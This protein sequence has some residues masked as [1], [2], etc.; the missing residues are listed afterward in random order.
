VDLALAG[1][2]AL[3]TGASRGIG[4][5]VA[6]A[7]AAEGVALHLA[8]RSRERLEEAAG[9]LRRAHGVPVAVHPGDLAV[10]G[11]VDALADAVAAATGA[12]D[13]LVNNAGAIPAGDLDAVDGGTWRSAW[14]LK[15]LGYV[16]LSRRCLALMRAAGSGVIVN[17]I[18]AAGERPDA[19]YVA[20]SA[21]NA[22]L[23]AF[24][25]AL[26][27]DAPR[28]GIRVVGVNPGVTR[29]ERMERQA[30]RR[31]AA[32]GGDPETWREALRDL[33]FGRPAEPREVAD[34]VA[35]LASPRAAYVSGTVVTVDGGASA[36]S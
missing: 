19:R 12:P 6:E 24:T 5:A 4:R 15:V 33:P 3:I 16:D 32:A 2:T 29:T 30:R 10:P 23:M 11:A 1:R 36:A 25:R 13:V 26:G 17:V 35:F 14:E 20:G 31:V 9:A 18:G 34:V 28:H 21:G 22:A 8:A 7:L 27:A